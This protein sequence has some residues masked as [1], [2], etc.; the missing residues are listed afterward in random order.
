[1]IQEALPEA[2]AGT[3]AAVAATTVMATTTEA[4]A[5]I[6]GAAA[7]TTRLAVEGTTP[8]AAVAAAAAGSGP[9]WPREDSWATCLATEGEARHCV[10]T[11]GFLAPFYIRLRSEVGV[12]SRVRNEFLTLLTPT[13]GGTQVRPESSSALPK[14]F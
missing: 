10:A 11:C 2:E 4:E 8:A 7:T 13:V 1:M 3:P 12:R 14:P 5:T 6:T 9:A